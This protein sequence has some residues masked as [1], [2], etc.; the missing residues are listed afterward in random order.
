MAETQAPI[1]DAVGDPTPIGPGTLVETP[2]EHKSFP[3]FDAS[4]FASQLLWLAITFV[5][6]FWILSK[7]A[8]PRIKGILADRRDRIAGDLD[9]AEKMKLQSEQAIANYEKALAEARANANRIAEGARD[10]SKAAS[11]KQRAVIEAGLGKQL[12]EAE[13]R[14]AT[15]K[16]RAV[17]EVGTIA[18]EATEA[19]VAALTDASVSRQEIETAVA[20]AMNR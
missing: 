1:P 19:V 13:A 16:S 15:I 7:F 14:I 5:L 4:T 12:A 3:P 2:A 20:A 18:G 8:I 6:L 11:A 17:A 9:A 10:E